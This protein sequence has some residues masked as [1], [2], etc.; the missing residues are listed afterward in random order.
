MGLWHVKHMQL[1]AL[2]LSPVASASQ[3]CTLTL[4]CNGSHYDIS[5]RGVTWLGMISGL[6][7]EAFSSDRKLSPTAQLKPTKERE[8]KKRQKWP[9]AGLCCWLLISVF[10]FFCLLLTE[11]RRSIWS[12]FQTDM[13]KINVSMLEFVPLRLDLGLVSTDRAF[14]VFSC[15]LHCKQPKLCLFTHLCL[16][17]RKAAV[18]QFNLKRSDQQ[19]SA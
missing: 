16:A 12:F 14:S 10:R 8:S 6:H 1:G 5:L 19:L 15:Q 4:V 17:L 18:M 13:Q 11:T 7:I 9:F 3:I 2:A